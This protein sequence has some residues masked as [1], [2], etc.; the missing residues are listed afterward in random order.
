MT[1]LPLVVTLEQ[2]L[3]LADLAFERR[4]LRLAGWFGRSAHE[5]DPDHL[6]LDPR[7]VELIRSEIIRRPVLVLGSLSP[8]AMRRLCARLH[9]AVI[10][11]SATGGDPASAL[12]KRFA[13]YGAGYPT[14][15]TS[16]AKA[17]P[18]FPP[19]PTALLPALRPHH[20]VKNLLVF[21]PLLAAHRWDEP[22]LWAKAALALAAFSLVS[23][24]VYLANDLFDLP[25]DRR[26]PVKR[27]RPLASGAMRP[28]Q[29]LVLFFAALAMGLA[30]AAPAGFM[31]ILS[32]YAVTAAAYSLKLKTWPGIDLTVL[33][34]LYSL[35]LSAGGM[36]T[37]IPVSGWLMAYG[38][39][40]FASLA[41]AKRY[42]ELAGADSGALPL[43]QR[44]GYGLA[45]LHWLAAAGGL[46]AIG[47][48]LVLLA[49]LQQPQAR[50]L[51]GQPIFLM[52][53]GTVLLA[54]LLRLWRLVVRNRLTGD[55]VVFALRD[56]VSLGAGASAL[57]LLALAAG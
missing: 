49:Y 3:T 21:V 27:L 7:V 35:R 50:A 16:A 40:I 43:P 47:S 46:S 24:A 31:A 41:M 30:L 18:A 1:D 26:H 6:P 36:A 4:L 22:D 44:R 51:Y 56:P 17:L 33:V 2:G 28:T 52:V 25:D 37:G 20:W 14:L 12:P 29:A 42:A 48:A 23:S 38:A 13:L 57:A 45:D 11:V 8:D 55:P 53:A 39:C 54:W 32:L 15:R 9:P 34:G 10:P 5:P 19:R